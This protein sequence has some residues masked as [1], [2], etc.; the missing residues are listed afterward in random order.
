MQIWS[1]GITKLY[2]FQFVF[3]AIVWLIFADAYKVPKFMFS[4]VFPYDF[5]MRGIG[6]S[7]IPILFFQIFVV[8]SYIAALKNSKKNK[9]VNLIAGIISILWFVFVSLSI[10]TAHLH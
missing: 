8:G 9:L 10:L 2:L 3:F 6:V 4:Y 1:R 5:S 7:M